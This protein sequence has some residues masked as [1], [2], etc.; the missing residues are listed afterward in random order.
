MGSSSHICGQVVSTIAAKYRKRR[1]VAGGLELRLDITR[2]SD[3]AGGLM[4]KSGEGKGKIRKERKR[5]V[6]ERKI[7]T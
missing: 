3:T 1:A 4:V 6:K 7:Q 2:W 5:N